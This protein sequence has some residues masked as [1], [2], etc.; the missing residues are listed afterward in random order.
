MRSWFRCCSSHT[1]IFS[2]EAVMITYASQQEPAW[3]VDQMLSIEYWCMPTTGSAP[4]L[5]GSPTFTRLVPIFLPLRRRRWYD[6]L[7]PTLPN[8]DR[9]ESIHFLLVG[10]SMQHSGRRVGGYAS[11]FRI[12]GTYIM[13]LSLNY[14]RTDFCGCN[15]DGGIWSR[16][17]TMMAQ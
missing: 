13:P 7:K 10:I 9:S 16:R 1:S 17:N 15:F 3:P 5:I 14:Y 4:R 2:E 6:W 8:L 12:I 11:Q